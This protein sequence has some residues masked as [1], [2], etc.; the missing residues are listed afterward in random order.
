ML[1]PPTKLSAPRHLLSASHQGSQ[2]P[3]SCLSK[4]RSSHPPS[5]LKARNCCVP[6]MGAN[7][8]VT[9]YLSTKPRWHLVPLVPQYEWEIVTLNFGF[10]IFRFTC[11]RIEIESSMT[12]PKSFTML[13]LSLSPGCHF[14]HPMIVFLVR[15]CKSVYL[16]WLPLYET[17]ND[18]YHLSCW[19]FCKTWWIHLSSS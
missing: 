6:L 17:I 3:T 4:Q 8:L 16:I 10:L 1:L 11:L 2:V 15:S 12:I 7:F 5:L 18:A 14:V 13:R 19:I 9:P